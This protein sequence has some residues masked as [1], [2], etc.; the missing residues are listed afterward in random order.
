VHNGG[1]TSD[2]NMP[3][4]YEA[5]VET[6]P[7]AL[8]GVAREL[9]WHLK[10][11]A[12]RSAGWSEV[13]PHQLSLGAPQLF[14]E[15]LPGAPLARVRE[16][17]LAHLLCVLEAAVLERCCV[18][19]AQLDSEVSAV[20][21][22][23]AGA[24]ASALARLG[25]AAERA[26]AMARA[27]TL[28]ALEEERQILP[29]A[30]PVTFE[31]YRRITRAKASVSCTAT[32]LLAQL[33]ETGQR[34][35]RII[36]RALGNA[37]HAIQFERDVLCWERD[38]RTGSAWVVPLVRG[39]RSRRRNGERATEPDLVRRAVL[40]SGVLEMLL[41]MAV[42][43]YRK[44]RRRACALGAERIW[45]WAASREAHLSELLTCE[46]ESAG[47]VIRLQKLA[48]WAREVFR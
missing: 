43:E 1:S 4:L 2:G 22:A 13:F 45:A 16:A 20:L 18:D 35:S 27:E 37:W 42:S 19:R 26:H 25:P 17:T 11:V 46:S 47:Y 24:R 40:G 38:W 12:D 36:H 6:L 15:A 41:G 33:A 23:L 14:A 10:L 7:P 31:D 29:E 39:I 21:E 28:A 48:P 44:T 30:R 34:E 3:L 8:R 9:P 32:L 5:F